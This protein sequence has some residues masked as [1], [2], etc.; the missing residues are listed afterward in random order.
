MKA[1]DQFSE[2][3]HKLLSLLDRKSF[4]K[5]RNRCGQQLNFRATAAQVE[6]L[7]SRQLLS[8][9][10]PLIGVNEQPSWQAHRSTTQTTNATAAATGYSPNQI[11]TAYGVSIGNSAY[12]TGQT[13]A[14]V[15]AYHNP[16]I[17]SDLLA[18]DAAFGLSNPPSFSVMSQ[19][20]STT[21]F[22]GVDPTGNWE[23][24][25]ALDVEWAHALAPGANIVLVEAN[26]ASSSD[27]FTAV[28]FAAR[29]PGVS[30][31][32]M[33]W[34]SAE[35]LGE[36]TFDSVFTTPAGHQGVTF[37]ASTGDSGSPGG[38]PAYSS[39]VVAVGG[40]TLTISATGSYGSEAGWAKG[41][42]G[43]SLY[44]AQPAYQKGVVMQSTTMRTAPDVS[45]DADPNSGVSVYSSY[46]NGTGTPWMQ[47]GGTSLSAPAFAGIVA[48][49]NQARVLNG[50]TTLDGP[51]QT[52]PM[53][54]SLA[55]QIPTAFNDVTTGNN[56]TAAGA[57]YDLVTGLGTPN[58]NVLVS[59]MAGS[60]STSVNHLVFEK[61]PSTGIAGTVLG[62]IIVAVENSAG[63]IVT[64]D[65]STITLSTGFTTG[66]TVSVKAVNGIATFSNLTMTTA[67]NQTLT[68]SDS[69]VGVQG[70]TFNIKINPAA[71]S[72]VSFTTM[73][74][75][76]TAGTPLTV[77]VA[78][79]QDA[80]GNV[81]TS[82]N[83]TVTLAVKTGPGSFASGSTFTATSINGIAKFSSLTLNTAGTYTLS[84]TQGTLTSGVSGSLTISPAVASKL[85]ITTS[86]PTGTAGTKLAA[87]KASITDAFGN[88]VTTNTSSVTIAVKSGSAS[89]ASGSTLTAAAVNG[90][91]TFSALTLNI[92]GTYAL[93]ATAGT[94]TSAISG[95][96][97]V[98]AAAASKLVFTVIPSTGTVNTLLATITVAIQ[99]AYG[100]IVTG[101]TSSVT[102]AVGTGPSGGGFVVGSTLTV[103][104]VNGVATFK[105]IKIAK[106]GTYALKATDGSLTAA[107]SGNIVVS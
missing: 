1:S 98:S 73:P 58:V 38:F 105:N 76:G 19:T 89:F 20:G 17:Q 85:L 86:P 72:K 67:G 31:V 78:T 34:G 53:L 4:R 11:I 82:N 3:A 91:A 57:G 62:T 16:N 36:T 74:V 104:A 68:A 51:S 12:G 70:L 63:Q 23:I 42:G 2:I 22:P 8:A 64:T 14:I 30:V 75:T 32:S 101:N 48:T 24:E 102:L 26:S 41:G 100:N 40:T 59:N 97:V 33:S 80:Y 21:S 44:E 29:L 52:L 10:N 39:N 103:A 7:E 27:L 96:I 47:V 69:G 81:I 18:F 25:E 90:V 94:L 88:V 6:F 95:N 35:F 49:I 106:A 55:K 83:A 46:L 56:G 93:S 13:I 84:A 66:S 79:V 77:V 99:D 65:S 43:I 50:L 5:P 54:Y 45:F 71:A 61:A 92:A 107:T 37:L 28:Q 87:L 15:D 9:V 60:L